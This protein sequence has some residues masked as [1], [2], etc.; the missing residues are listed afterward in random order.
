MAIPY[1]CVSCVEI[2]K[3][4]IRFIWLVSLVDPIESSPNVKFAGASV[5]FY[6]FIGQMG[7]VELN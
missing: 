4:S 5:V 3:T 1:V 2:H 6:E 7:D